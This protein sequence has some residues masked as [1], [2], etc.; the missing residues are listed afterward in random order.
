LVNKKIEELTGLGLPVDMICTSHGSIWRDN[1]GQIIKK[2]T[3]WASNYQENQVT[4]IYDTMWNG[5][6]SMADNI[7]KGIRQADDNVNVKIYN[8]ANT[9]K[10]DIITEVFK[11]KAILVGSPTINKGILYSIAGILEIIRGMSFKNKKAAAFGCFGWHAECVHVIDEELKN[12]GFEL[13][14]EGLK[15]NWNPDE[16]G[17]QECVDYGKS[18]ASK[19]I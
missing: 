7:A 5:T 18:F 10:N 1:P 19:L 4:I 9:D 11:S 3:E 16:Q 8:A 15:I 14:A 12:A 17:V 6:R 13:I 2:Y